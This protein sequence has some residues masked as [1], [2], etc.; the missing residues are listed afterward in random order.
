MA[1]KKLF[2][3]ELNRWDREN[4][5]EVPKVPL[6]VVL[7]NIRSGMNVG[8]VFRTSDAFLV[9]RVILTGISA[10]PP[11]KEILKAA[12]GASETVDWTYY[13]TTSEAIHE[14]K[15]RGYFCVGVEQTN[16]SIEIREFIYRFPM[17]LVLGNE[18]SGISEEVLDLLDAFMEVPQFGTKHSLNVSVCAG[19]VLW[20]TLRNYKKLQG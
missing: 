16:K 20:E 7:D 13:Q 1:V 9:E 10:T 12:I 17:A 5:K 6:V 18:V 11:H 15:D 4:F 14:L 19:I 8:S 3:E 2:S